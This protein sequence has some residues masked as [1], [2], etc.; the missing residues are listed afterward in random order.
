[1]PASTPATAQRPSTPPARGR[2]LGLDAL[3]EMLQFVDITPGKALRP[4]AD[5]RGD[6]PLVAVGA[7][8]HRLPFQLADLHD[9]LIADDLHP[10]VVAVAARA[11]AREQSQPAAFQLDVDQHVVVEIA[12]HPRCWPRL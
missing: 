10:G 2:R 1:M 7:H 12:A 6:Q 8:H 4:G 5:D 11:D 9:A 3:D